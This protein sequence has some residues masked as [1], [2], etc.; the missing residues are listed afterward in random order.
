MNIKLLTEDARY[1]FKSGGNILLIPALGRQ[2][3]TDLSWKP[4]TVLDSKTQDSQGYIERL[5]T[6]Q[7]TKTNKTYHHKHTNKQHRELGMVV[8]DHN[9]SMWTLWQA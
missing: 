1:S 9:S 5:Q 2:R 6:K 3:Q 4:E 8:S 7:K